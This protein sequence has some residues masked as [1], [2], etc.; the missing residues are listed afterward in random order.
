MIAP[1]PQPGNNVS[2]GF[3]CPKCGERDADELVWQDDHETVRC[4][5][6]GTRYRPNLE[7]DDAETD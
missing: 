5:R 6:C 1:N 3:G 2:P 4:A 7:T